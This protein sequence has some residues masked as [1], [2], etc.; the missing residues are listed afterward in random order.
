MSTTAAVKMLAILGRMCCSAEDST[1]AR[2]LLGRH[3]RFLSG[4]DAALLPR[5]HGCNVPISTLPQYVCM[6]CPDTNLCSDCYH[7]S[8][9]ATHDG[10]L[11]SRP[12]RLHTFLHVSQADVAMAHPA[13]KRN[14]R[15]GSDLSAFLLAFMEE[16]QNKELAFC[17]ELM[18]EPTPPWAK[19]EVEPP[20][21]ETLPDQQDQAGHAGESTKGAFR[22]RL[23]LLKGR[24]PA[25]LEVFNYPGMR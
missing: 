13:G 2:F 20:T 4:S 11:E 17:A 9:A 18:P 23:D 3:R 19:G 15:R 12:C 25:M 10:D 5:C 6:T 22:M 1:N 24:L 21:R 16:R 7:A 14:A 8:Q